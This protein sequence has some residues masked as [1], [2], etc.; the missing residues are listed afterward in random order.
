MKKFAKFK[1]EEKMCLIFAT[2][3]FVAGM[4]LICMG[5]EWAFLSII[6][7][8]AH[9]FLLLKVMSNQ[10]DTIDKLIADKEEYMIARHKE[11]LSERVNNLKE[12]MKVT[13]SDTDSRKAAN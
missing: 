5:R 10:I 12:E 11:H 7:W 4:A 2:I 1:D 13:R 9:G 6:A 8:L 3:F